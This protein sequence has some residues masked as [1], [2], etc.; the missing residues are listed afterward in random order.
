VSARQLNDPALP[1]TLLFGPLEDALRTDLRRWLH[2][3][4]PGALP[5]DYYDR[6]HH[7]RRWQ[8]D[9]AKAGFV[10]VSW[11]TEFGGRGLG[12]AAEAAIA[13]ELAAA[14]APELINRLALFT[15]APTVLE[16]GTETQK[17][18]LLPGMLDASEIW[19]QGF[20]E[21]GAGSDLAAIRTTARVDDDKLVVNGQKV[22]T[23][24]ADV[25]QWCIALVR[26]DPRSVRHRGLSLIALP[27]AST[28]VSSRPLLDVNNDPH[29]AEV[30][31][32]DVEVP[33]ANVIGELNEGWRV[34]MSLLGY[35]RGLFALERLIHTRVAFN[36]LLEEMDASGRAIDK[37][38][39]GR[40]SSELSVL[41]AQVYGTLA[42]QAAG[43]LRPGQTAV[44]KLL[45][46]AAVQAVFA[47]AVDMLGPGAAI[48]A[49]EWTEGLFTARSVSIYGGTAEIQR[50][51]VARQLL[52]LSGERA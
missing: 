43:E 45:L 33:R 23:T 10:G 25:A 13:A 38:I 12:V 49:G 20:S 4:L 6:V 39:V 44:D 27:M 3:H 1:R 34:A 48:E 7:L 35:E 19:C 50:N 2:R 9:L 5:D 41:E 47:W 21:P 30:F 24:R 16:F 22:W 17:A 36:R 11:P 28:G 31:F 29:F 26:T 46:A 37:N 32:D 14:S 8:S 40:V 42:A 18:K 15:I 52:N 51:I